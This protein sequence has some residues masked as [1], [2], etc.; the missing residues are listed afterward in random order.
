MFAW[1][2]FSEV[3]DKNRLLRSLLHYWGYFLFPTSPTIWRGS[4][5]VRKFFQSSPCNL[6]CLS[7]PI[8][9]EVSALIVG[10]LTAWPLIWWHLCRILLVLLLP[11]FL[12]VIQC[13][14]KDFSATAISL[15]G[16]LH[17]ALYFL[18][19][20]HRRFWQDYSLL[21]NGFFS[22]APFSHVMWGVEDKLE[23]IQWFVSNVLRFI[24]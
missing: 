5:H 20:W 10:S 22:S 17:P 15:L 12:G 24:Y 13:F 6:A 21:S 11:V 23:I 1:S 16:S 4:E 9:L 19:S 7:R 3:S 2:G 18:I 8:S 14:W